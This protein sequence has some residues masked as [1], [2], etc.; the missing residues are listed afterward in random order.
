MASA[1]FAGFS[2][3]ASGSE[4]VADQ[5]ECEQRL[6]S[7][8][9]TDLS[10]YQSAHANSSY[11]GLQR[12][13]PRVGWSV[14][15]RDARSHAVQARIRVLANNQ[16]YNGNIAVVGAFNNW[17]ESLRPGDMLHPD[18]DDPSIL[19]TVITGIRH[20]MS[21]EL[22]RD[23]QSVLD[24]AAPMYMTPEYAVRKEES[25]TTLKAIFW[26]PEAPGLYRSQTSALNL[27]SSSR[28][29]LK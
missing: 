13:K 3:S 2:I 4:S 22:L 6:T 9:R 5:R 27:T 21:Y 7:A 25:D 24:P 26:D 16:Q 1:F 10:L 17:G 23:G 18:V 19:T 29:G 28:L 15:E 8:A 14:V 20:E 12:P 11:R